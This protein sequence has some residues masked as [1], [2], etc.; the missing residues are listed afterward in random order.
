MVR[1]TAK[2]V[3]DYGMGC[4]YEVMLYATTISHVYSGQ[5]LLAVGSLLLVVGESIYKC[6]HICEIS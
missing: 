5:V 4:G 3:H 6:I 2:G 1:G